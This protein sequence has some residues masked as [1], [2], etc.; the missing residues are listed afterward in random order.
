[1]W[2]DV[3]IAMSCGGG[4]LVC[5]WVMHALGGFGNHSL[6][7]KAAAAITNDELPDA[8]DQE[9]VL[10]VADRL[11]AYAS[12]MAAD[13]DAHQTKVLEVN[14]SLLEGQDSSPEAVMEAVNQLIE[15]NEQMQSQLQEAQNRIHEQTVQIE[16]AER[17]AHTD[18]LTR[19]PNRGAFDQHLAERHQLG[20]ERAGTLALLDV[21]HFKK[22]ND[23]YGHRAGDEVLKVVANMLQV[24]LQS[25]GL[26]SRYGGEE[27][28]IILD[29][30]R[31]EEASQYLEAARVAIGERDIL[32]EDKRLRV[33]A[34]MGVAELTQDESIEQWLQR[35]DD[36]L[37]HSKESGRD[38]AH[39]MEGSEPIRIALQGEFA[40]SASQS[41]GSDGSES[42]S[43]PEMPEL[44]ANQESDR[45][46]P[47]PS[48][49]AYLPDRDVL[50]GEFEEIR[51]RV[52]ESVA[53]FVM[54]IRFASPPSESTARSMLQIVRANLRS[55]DRVGYEDDSTVL[56]CMPSV[57][58]NTAIAKG[59]QICRSASTILQASG[60]TSTRS[61]TV[62]V[63]ESHTREDFS[64]VVSR[65]V[66]LANQCYE[67]GED[68]LC[69]PSEPVT[70]G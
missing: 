57:D 19:V 3:A 44:E 33:N 35:A 41:S 5:G 63:T 2:L 45:P 34:S 7:H 65:V 59:K 48:G 38:C 37:Y 42:K 58:E 56:I 68:C 49:L 27:F 21:D 46:D 17:R 28:A 8:R 10:E 69:G 53:I 25:F 62:G 32:F 70:T 51:E 61:V 22:F 1:M 66:S 24:R 52:G 50:G 6:V 36:G 40:G 29:D 11:K 47:D 67:L 12:N 64:N 14:N 26:V 60:K 43:M 9:R 18:A 16:S 54:A 13:V 15:A 31:L 39:R 23:V 4:G 30:C 55:V 20:P